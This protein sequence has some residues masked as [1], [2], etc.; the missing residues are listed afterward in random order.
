[1]SGQSNDLGGSKK[2]ASDALKD[3][4]TTVRDINNYN[5]CLI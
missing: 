5:M 3:E 4:N 1:M 2:G